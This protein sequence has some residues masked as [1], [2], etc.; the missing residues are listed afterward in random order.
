MSQ[1]L[2]TVC[3]K[4]FNFRYFPLDGILSYMVNDHTHVDGV[5]VVQKERHPIISW[6]TQ[7]KTN[8]LAESRVQNAAARLVLGLQPRDHIKPALFELHWLPVHLRIDYKLCLLMHSA[9]V[10]CCPRYISDIVQTTAASS[11]RQG[12][13]SSTDTS[14]YTVPLTY[15]TSSLEN[16]RFQWLVHRFG[17][18]CQQTF[19]TLQTSLNSSVISRPTFLTSILILSRVFVFI[20]FSGFRL[21]IELCNTPVDSFCN[22]RTLS[23][24]SIVLYRWGPISSHGNGHSSPH[25]HPSLFGPHNSDS[26]GRTVLQTVAKNYAYVL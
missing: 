6:I 2:H 10:Q 14:S 1:R 25:P 23:N 17:T 20:R 9:T 19:G 13:R 21:Y 26:T 18:L 8:W 15:I 16:A 22:S 3:R 24:F 4:L 7:S 12:L 11:R 5:T